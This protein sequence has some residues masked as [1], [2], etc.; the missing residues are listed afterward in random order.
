MAD[1]FTI[2]G[3]VLNIF[4]FIGGYFLGKRREKIQNKREIILEYYPDLIENLRLSVPHSH[5]QF[6]EGMVGQFDKFFEVLIGMDTDGTLKIIESLDKPLYDDMQIL[7]NEIIPTLDI[8]QEKRWDSWKGIPDKWVGWLLEA[9][10]DLPELKVTPS[11]FVAQI[12]NLFYLWRG[13]IEV[14]KKNFDEKYDMHFEWSDENTPEIK[15]RV[16]EKF[17]KIAEDEWRPIKSEYELVNAR[18]KE[19]IEDKI[20]PRMETTLSDL[21][22]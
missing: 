11:I 18:L 12:T 1:L 19:L 9:K 14:A 8:I 15:M 5:K 22:K 21:G 17:R 10:E 2:G 16:F 4:T 6:T 20:I 3:W 7:L 13:N